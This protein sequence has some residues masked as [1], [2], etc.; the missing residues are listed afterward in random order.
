MNLM[1]LYELMNLEPMKIE[2]NLHQMAILEE[3]C[4]QSQSRSLHKTKA[5]CITYRYSWMWIN[6]EDR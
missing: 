6:M 3:S 5:G 4:C 1:N 2:E